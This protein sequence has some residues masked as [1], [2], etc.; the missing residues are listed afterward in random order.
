MKV[1]A[2]YGSSRKE[3]NSDLLADKVLYDIK[4]NKRYLSDYN[5]TPIDDKRHEPEGFLERVNDDYNELIS[6]MLEHDVVIYVTPLYWYGMSGL[7]KNFIDRSTESMRIPERNFKERMKEIKHYVVIVG[8]DSPYEKGMPLVQQFA[9]IFD[10]MGTR[11][12][13]WIIGDGNKPGEVLDDEVAMENA[14][15]MNAEVKQLFPNK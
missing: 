15:K 7:M 11:L 5:I 2:L 9:Y 3:G 6:E 4:H 10:F 13:G 14:S 8:G 1:F 12:E